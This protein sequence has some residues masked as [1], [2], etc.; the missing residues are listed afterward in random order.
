MC[1]RLT[2]KRTNVIGNR[3]G[4]EKKILSKLC[5]VYVCVQILENQNLYDYFENTSRK[6]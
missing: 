3:A 5:S 6:D 1:N 4:V 2:W